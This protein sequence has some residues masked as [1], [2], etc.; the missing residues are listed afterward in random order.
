LYEGEK[1]KRYLLTRNTTLVILVL[2]LFGLGFRPQDDKGGYY[3]CHADA[4]ATSVPADALKSTISNNTFISSVLKDSPSIITISNTFR[5]PIVA[6][7]IVVGYTDDDNN[8]L[9]QAPFLAM[10]PKVRSRFQLLVP[11]EHV[12][13]LKH[14]IAVGGSTRLISEGF[15]VM[16]RC[17]TKASI[18]AARIMFA[19]ESTQT[20]AEHDWTIDPTIASLPANL[21]LPFNDVQTP[22]SILARLKIT[23]EGRIDGVLP[24]GGNSFAAIRDL[25]SAL[26]GWRFYPAQRNGQ[27]IPGGL[28]LLLRF[29]AHG[30]PTASTFRIEPEDVRVPLIVVDLIPSDEPA[31]W[32]VW[33]GRRPGGTTLD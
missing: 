21:S 27:S 8:L 14:P 4:L 10:L 13:I 28:T 24:I 25:E 18:L 15:V 17:P 32:S 31:I 6:F 30:T 33:Y 29:N 26:D 7:E 19:D 11:A 12:H 22:S 2:S 3:L 5:A 20:W 16:R 1:M 9:A 23:A